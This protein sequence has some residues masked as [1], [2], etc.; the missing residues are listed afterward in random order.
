MVDSFGATDNYCPI[1][2]VYPVYEINPDEGAGTNNPFETAQPLADLIC[3]TDAIF[4][5]SDISKCAGSASEPRAALASKNGGGNLYEHRR[6]PTSGMVRGCPRAW[7][8]DRT[9][10]ASV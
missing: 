5:G 3:G 2:F 6:I 10:K 7:T 4:G 8:L 9:T 1:G